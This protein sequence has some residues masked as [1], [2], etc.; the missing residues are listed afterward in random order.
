M[1]LKSPTCFVYVHVTWKETVDSYLC[2]HQ[3]S[4]VPFAA[5]SHCI[6]RILFIRVKALKTLNN[7]LFSVRHNGHNAAALEMY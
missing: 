4:S 7:C 6:R 3:D 2:C 1:F 5:F